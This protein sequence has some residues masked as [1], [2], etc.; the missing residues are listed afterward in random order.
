VTAW[1]TR[2]MLFHDAQTDTLGVAEAPDI[3]SGISRGEG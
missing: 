1:A 2:D 3:V